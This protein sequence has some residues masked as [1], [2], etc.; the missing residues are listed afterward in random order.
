MLFRFGTCHAVPRNVFFRRD[1]VKKKYSLGT[2][3][4]RSARPGTTPKGTSRLNLED[5]D[6]RVNKYRPAQQD[7]QIRKA[8]QECTTKFNREHAP[9][10]L[11]WLPARM[12]LKVLL[13][14]L[15]I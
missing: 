10:H 7:K 2:G 8:K 5:H 15:C 14:S 11:S 9:G 4:T 3:R 1:F 12:L 13:N 6:E